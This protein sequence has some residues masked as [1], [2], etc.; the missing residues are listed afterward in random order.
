MT[1][2]FPLRVELPLGVDATGDFSAFA[3]A[4][5]LTVS[6]G[7]RA[8][9]T[10]ETEPPLSHVMTLRIR[11]ADPAP[12]LHAAVRGRL[13][14]EPAAGSQPGK[15]VLHPLPWVSIALSRWLRG[16]GAPKLV[17]YGNVEATS[18]ADAAKAI[19]KTQKLTQAVRDQHLASFIAGKRWINVAAGDSI[20]R[21]ATDGALGGFR[22]VDLSMTNQ[23][24]YFIN[25]AHFFY[26][27]PEINSALEGHPLLAALKPGQHDLRLATKSQRRYVS[28][29]ITVP[30]GAF[31][32][33]STASPKIQTAI[34]AAVPGDVV[35]VL[36]TNVYNEA[37]LITKEIQVISSASL[38]VKTRPDELSSLP[39]IAPVTGSKKR[40]VHFKQSGSASLKGFRIKDGKTSRPTDADGGGILVE[41]S[42][43]VDIAYNYIQS[44]EAVRGGGIA[45]TGCKN[46]TIAH[47]RIEK[48]SA[49]S[50]PNTDNP[51]TQRGQ[52]GGI[53]VVS[54]HSIWLQDNGIAANTAQNF[55]GGIAILSSK[56][57]V[58][59]SNEIGDL[60]L[61]AGNKVTD[62]VVTFREF[63]KDANPRGGGGGIGV[64]SSD[65][66]I[67]R[68]H[69]Y[70]NTSSRGGG[71]ELFGLSGGNIVGNV[72][73]FNSTSPPGK[74]EELGGDGGGIAVNPITLTAEDALKTPRV[75]IADNTIQD[76]AAGDDGGGIYATTR[77]VLW[78][79]N[80]DITRNTAYGN[81]GGIRVSFG[82]QITSSGGAIRDNTCNLNHKTGGGG[83]LSVFNA[84][85]YVENCAIEGNT[86][87]DFGGG[88]VYG[89]T[90]D[91]DGF[92]NALADS[93]EYSFE[94]LLKKYGFQH[95][96]LALANCKIPGGPTG[97]NKATAG[98]GLYIAY[99]FYAFH[100]AIRNVFFAGN[101][102]TH[103][104]PAKAFNVVIESTGATQPAVIT[105]P[106][107]EPLLLSLSP[108]AQF[109]REFDLP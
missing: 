33:P 93:W 28:Q 102:N 88:G 41:D 32:T 61:H 106:Q 71:I 7:L 75:D 53:F 27:F 86:A 21:A 48:N 100:L 82:A 24:D 47:N 98:G 108:L 34:D 19:L 89:V 64:G 6:F 87:L 20:G 96:L 56:G 12:R 99:K 1:D 63:T 105:S 79:E 31:L 68:N 22:S 95:G 3:G 35:I 77:S 18:A 57:V 85:A 70:Y 5:D 81:G 38:T 13:R 104:N 76:N 42:T 101:M 73:K 103:A 9:S 15:L 37:L 52:G 30:D 55:G 16:S 72:I 17:T 69:L 80:N 74:G 109:S 97:A 49:L 4:F 39:T 51:P 84:T 10:G 66:A 11:E 92:Y 91:Y 40:A 44:N 46:V 94:A 26:R 60:L 107:T 23:D 50:E 58:V 83:G 90:A 43:D 29:G 36:D 25:P 2:K 62:L 8:P 59:Q 54:S 45:V 65:V 78:L 67:V 14:Y